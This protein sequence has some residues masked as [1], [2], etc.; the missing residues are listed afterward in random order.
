[1]IL[2]L[3]TVTHE[4]AY[5]TSCFVIATAIAL[6]RALVFVL[7]VP[8]LKKV[9]TAK[10]AKIGVLVT[11]GAKPVGFDKNKYTAEMVVHSDD[12]YKHLGDGPLLH[13]IGDGYMVRQ[14]VPVLVKRSKKDILLSHF[15]F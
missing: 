7:P 4:I 2:L 6:F 3:K 5:W 10:M 14:Q 1:M 13:V 9:F 8:F 11:N 15:A 12:F